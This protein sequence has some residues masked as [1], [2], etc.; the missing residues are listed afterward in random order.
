MPPRKSPSPIWQRVT[1]RLSP[2]NHEWLREKAH[3]ER[4][5]QAATLNEALDI[6][7]IVDYDERIE[8]AE[9]QARKE[10]GEDG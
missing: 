4:K 7:R 10:G 5:S 8:A 9:A 1:V 2:V 3:R 6:A